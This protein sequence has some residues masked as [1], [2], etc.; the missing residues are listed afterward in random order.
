MTNVVPFVSRAHADPAVDPAVARARA[1]VEAD[2]VG[3]VAK[4]RDIIE[5]VLPLPT[6]PSEVERTLQAL[7]DVISAIEHTT[8]V[9]TCH[10]ERTPV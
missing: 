3:V 9:L 4:I 6:E 1:S 10:G 7:M 2:L 8:D 5:R